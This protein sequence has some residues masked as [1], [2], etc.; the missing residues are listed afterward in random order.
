MEY[1]LAFYAER[2]NFEAVFAWIEARPAV[3]S[4]ESR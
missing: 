1:L 4:L 3:V 2:S